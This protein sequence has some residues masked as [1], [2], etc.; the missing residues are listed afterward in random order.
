MPSTWRAGLLWN[1]Y[2]LT[3]FALGLSY[4]L[5][6]RVSGLQQIIYLLFVVAAPIAILF[7]VWR[8]RPN[9]R[10]HWLMFAGG[11]ALWSAGDFYWQGYEW[12]LGKQAPYPSFA[13]IAYLAGY[14]VLIAGVFILVRGWGRPRL[15]NLLDAAIVLLAAGTLSM[16]FLLKPLLATSEPAFAK[17]IA[18][19]FPVMDFV[20]LVALTQLMFRRRAMS[21][22]LRAMTIGTI[23]LVI[24]DAAYS[25]LG[26]EGTYK[27]G[28]IIDAGWLASYALWAIAA[29]HPSMAST[30]SLPER[31]G[32]GL[33]FTRIGALLLAM[34]A[35]PVVLLAQAISDRP[36]SHGEIA[37]I[38]AAIVATTLLV[39]VRVWV[40]Q[41]DSKKAQAD[42][43]R[44]E[45]SSRIA[46]AVSGVGTWDMDLT[47]GVISMSDPL[48]QLIM[49]SLREPSSFEAWERFIHPDDRERVMGNFAQARDNGST[50]EHEYR[51]QQPNGAEGWMFSRGRVFHDEGGAPVRAIGVALDITGRHTLEEQ[52]SSSEEHFRL[53]ESAAKIGS[54]DM[55][56]TNGELVWSDSLRRL[57]DM[58]VDV[59]PTYDAFIDWIHPDDR[60]RVNREITLA[61]EQGTDF[62]QEYRFRH[63][64]GREGWMESRGRA[65]VD[66][67]GTRGRRRRRHHRPPCHARERPAKR[68]RHATRSGARWGRHLGRQPRNRQD[69]LVEELAPDRRRRR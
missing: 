36:I 60:A 53:A 63:A 56:L 5:F 43:G 51:F 57:M 25:K 41:R 24:A 18:V 7:G 16:L 45:E 14:P 34:L 1:G 21:V 27:S 35:A 9:P 40:L 48:R 22:S 64:D 69:H 46:Q 13:D 32:A 33:S 10:W 39:G 38:G 55:N 3:A 11:L 68:G 49:G 2:A 6:A 62:E 28:D 65:L 58:P 47:T 37:G 20:M 12:L 19:G 4:F 15:G 67:G 29:L 52:L 54:W 61:L 30:R 8:Y 31:E 42:L 44:S 17:L 59:A 26:L 23:A 66:D 50:F